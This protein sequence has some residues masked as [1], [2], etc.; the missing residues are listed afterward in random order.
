M[1]HTQ[2]LTHSGIDY[3]Q[4]WQVW[5]SHRSSAGTRYVELDR[6]ARGTSKIQGLQN[7][8]HSTCVHLIVFLGTW[9]SSI[10]Q[11]HHQ[12]FSTL[13]SALALGPISASQAK[14]QEA[15]HYLSNI[16]ALASR[17]GQSTE[18]DALFT[19]VRNECRTVRTMT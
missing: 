10:L 16:P 11:G 15:M 5:S 14:G 12:H 4:S 13:A 8:V 6:P 3:G 19:S 17:E 1:D 2:R 7:T 18:R 9:H